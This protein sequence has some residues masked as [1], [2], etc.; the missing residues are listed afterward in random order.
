MVAVV[1]ELM[2]LFWLFQGPAAAFGVSLH[3]H[4]HN[5]DYFEISK[6]LRALKT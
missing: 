2:I 1:V 4:L 6:T 5:M 3:I